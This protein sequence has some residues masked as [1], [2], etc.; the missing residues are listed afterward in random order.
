MHQK[1]YILTN[2]KKYKGQT[3]FSSFLMITSG[4]LDAAGLAL[5]VPTINILLGF[6]TNKDE[7]LVTSTFKNIFESIGIN[8]SLRYVLGFTAIIMLARSIFIFFQ[9]AYVGRLRYKY[10]AKI[11]K[12]FFNRLQRSDWESFKSTSQA[13]LINVITLQSSRSGGAFTNYLQFISNL[14]IVFF[15][16]ITSFVISWKIT[17]FALGCGIL[18]SFIFSFLTSISRKLGS[19]Q[20]DIGLGLL[21]NLNNSFMLSKYIRIHGKI[22]ETGDGVEEGIENSS[23]N[24]FKM[25]V[26]DSIFLSTYEYAFIGFL[27]LGLLVST[28]YFDIDQNAL[29]LLTLIFFRLFQKTKLAQQSLQFMNKNLP[30]LEAVNKEFASIKESKIKW[31]SNK[32]DGIKSGI[33]LKNISFKRD[34]E[35]IIKDSSIK[36]ESNKT[37]LLV[38]P[39]GSGK[40]TLVDII[41][42]L[43]KIDDGEILYDGKN[44]FSY[45]ESEF[46]SKISYVDQNPPLFNTTIL[47]NFLISNSNITMKEITTICE[48][49]K[50]NEKIKSL[51]KKYNTEVGDLGNKLSGG[52]KQ[53]ICL[54]RA[55]INYPDFLILDEAFSQL[56]SKSKEPLIETIKELKGNTTILIIS[57][58]IDALRLAD[59]VI[60]LKNAKL[61]VKPKNTDF[62]KYF[63][64]EGES[65]TRTP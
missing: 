1:E 29:A 49:L 39:S 62:I 55:L 2:L 23:E 60:E 24:H 42:G 47:N 22:K 45:T 57:H 64:A 11:Q 35:F 43:I 16:L 51:P 30:A 50:I 18:V 3:F 61:K 63:G 52:E 8:Y 46:K 32:Y 5:V 20:N 40:T 6:E 56:D 58:T 44:L 27:L 21:K 34:K 7:N 19:R 13:N 15:Y 4:L 59:K 14:G 25:S 33:E 37:T 10:I 28:R 31:G 26:I 53:R 48:K 65:R 9:G 17:L 36:I 54:A 41:S 38:G 12:R